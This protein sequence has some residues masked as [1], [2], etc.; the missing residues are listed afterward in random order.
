LEI[1]KRLTNLTEIE[2]EEFM[3]PIVTYFLISFLGLFALFIIIELI[4]FRT[5]KSFIIQILILINV[6]VLLNITTGFPAIRTAPG[7]ASP[8]TAIVIMFVC[9]LIGIIAHQIFY[10]KGEFSWRSFLNFLKPLVISP[11]L[12]LPLFDFLLESSASI[13]IKLIY[14]GILAFQNG[15]F[16]KNIIELK[17][18]PKIF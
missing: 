6:Y 10:R 18:D 7:D 8:I 5:V 17:A 2:K 11:I 13:S 4:L 14:F 9:T 16:W 1:Y 15:F 3:S 12:L